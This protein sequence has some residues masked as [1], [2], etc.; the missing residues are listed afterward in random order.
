MIKT[1]IIILIGVALAPVFALYS[2]SNSSLFYLEL[3]FALTGLAS[4]LVLFVFNVKLG[5]ADDLFSS[6]FILLKNT[7]AI[8]CV[9][10]SFVS[11]FLARNNFPITSSLLHFG[12]IIFTSLLF[13]ILAVGNRK[14][15]YPDR[16]D[17]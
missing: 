8:L 7:L 10:S 13:T 1:S 3:I 11:F 5:T 17:K 9:L 4:T 14:Q 2:S 15:S 6:N 12:T 16:N